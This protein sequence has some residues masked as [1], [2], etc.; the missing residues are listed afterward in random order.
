MHLCA[1]WYV[2]QFVLKLL[3]QRLRLPIYLL[4]ERIFFTIL[5]HLFFQHFVM[6]FLGLADCVS[7]T[8]L[9]Y[10]LFVTCFFYPVLFIL[11]LKTNLD[12]FLLI[13]FIWLHF[14]STTFLICLICFLFPFMTNFHSGSFSYILCKLPTVDQATTLYRKS[15]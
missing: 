8:F 14:I 11:L 15:L 10:F 9:F 2:L 6:F 7:L 3:F 4:I 1:L 13:S 5:I 12:V